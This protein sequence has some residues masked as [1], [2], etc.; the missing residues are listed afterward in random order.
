MLEGQGSRDYIKAK[1]FALQYPEAFEKLLSCVEKA[2]ISYLKAQIDHGAQA[3]QIFDS[4][5]GV[6]D[7]LCLDSYVHQSACRIFKAIKSYKADIPVIGFAKGI[8]MNLLDYAKIANPDIVGLDTNV[9]RQW[10]Q[11]HLG[12]DF[13][14]QGNLD[15]VVLRQGGDILARHIDQIIDDFGDTP[16]IFN[17]G[18]GIIKDTNPDHVAFAVQ[19]IKAHQ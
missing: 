1:G 10:A 14:L 18:H 9:N 6:L 2:T 19:R 12:E 15:P 3:I 16:F 5:A 13:V 7:P 8:G 11:D 4:W 17:L